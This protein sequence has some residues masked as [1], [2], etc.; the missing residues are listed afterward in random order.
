[1]KH[2][3]IISGVYDNFLEIKR[4]LYL[5]AEDSNDKNLYLPFMDIDQVN[6]CFKIYNANRQRKRNNW[7]EICKWIYAIQ[8][9]PQ[10]NNSMLIFGTLNFND[11]TLF[12]TNETTRKKYVERYLKD[13]T[14]HYIA[15][16]DYG[17]KK[18][19]EHYH[20]IALV[21]KK[22]DGTK[23]KCG[24]SKLLKVKMTKKDLKRTKNY[25][26]KLNNH[27]YKSSTKLKRIIRDRNYDLIDLVIKTIGDKS[28]EKFKLEINSY[29]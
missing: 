6:E 10:F 20:F 12:N 3:L 9:I 7:L 4:T 17:A 21:N 13:Q 16:I 23:W 29:E 24:G 27:S 28:F 22:I 14:L 8:K 25:L 15:N 1:M 2:H 26:L 5:S 19:R 18:G 11:E